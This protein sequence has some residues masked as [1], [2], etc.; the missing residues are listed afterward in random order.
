MV[1]QVN[2]FIGPGMFSHFGISIKCQDGW[3]CFEYAAG[4]AQGVSGS[5]SSSKSSASTNKVTV[6]K[7]N[8]PG[9]TKYI[10]DTKM[11]LQQII[12]FARN[13]SGFHNSKY[14]VTGNNCR[15]FCHIMAKFMGV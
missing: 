8:P 6:N 13:E 9:E 15:Q 12:D 14:D 3:Y 7:Y 11:G 10:G 5:N 4:G 2:L 1:H